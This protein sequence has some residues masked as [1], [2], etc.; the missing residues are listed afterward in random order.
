MRYFASRVME[1]LRSRFKR[2]YGE[3]EAERC[4]RRT[5][6]LVGRYGVGTDNAIPAKLWDEKDSVLI[7]YGD[8]VRASGENPLAT[9]NRFL[10]DR[11]RGAVSTVH[12]LPFFPYSSDDGFSVIDY[13]VVNEELGTWKDVAEIGANFGLMF[14]LVLNHV[15]RRSNWFKN[16][17]SGICPYLHYFIEVD[18]KTDLSTVVR[19][20]SSPL[21]TP[22]KMRD[23]TGCL[24]TTFSEDQ[25]DLDF[26]NPDV[27]FE[28]LDILIFYISKGARI[29]R[30]DAIAYLWKEIGTSCIHLPQTHE[31]VKLMRDVV[32]MVAPHVLLLTETN[33]PNEENLSYFGDGDEAHMVYQFPLPPLLLH[34]LLNANTKYLTKWA[35]SLPELPRGHSF[36]NFTASHD[37]I[38]VRP[39][40]E[41]LPKK[42]I[43]SLVDT[44]R[45]RKGL[46]STKKE[47]DGTESP[48]E[49]NITYFDALSE[50]DAKDPELDV[51]RFLCS[52]TVAMVLKGIPAIY[53]NSLVA[54]KN[55]LKGVRKTGRARAINRRKWDARKLGRL[56]RD[57]KTI[58][59]RVFN[60]YVRLLRLRAEHPAFH[61]DGCQKVFQLGDSVFALE[62]TSPDAKETIASISNFTEKQ[63]ELA[64]DDKIPSLKK[65]GRIK[66]IISGKLFGAGLS[67]ITLHPYQTVWLVAKS[68]GSTD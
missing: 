37:G 35:A 65:P 24:W 17:T 7:T 51:A 68:Q 55:D 50:P 14:D 49:L 46:I 40:E 2:L 43:D 19:P 33:V 44:I 60:E 27:L 16:F 34:A 67:R 45:K 52:Q 11:L 54:A 12:I 61:P 18:P 56:L 57:E 63:V 59:S 47:P 4:M 23:G 39:L 42:E 62:R 8:M 29:I 9:L 53:F 66:D 1:R 15:S 25:I 30:L 48:Y 32:E 10:T 31:I 41:I 58:N 5:E 64:I 38:G 13:R 36:L 20:R 28:F 21:L 6:M 22:V 3:E 26:A